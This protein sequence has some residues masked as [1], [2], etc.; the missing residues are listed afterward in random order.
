M[1]R[2]S[3]DSTQYVRMDSKPPPCR[4][5]TLVEGS[6]SEIESLPDERVLDNG[7]PPSTSQPPTE[8]HTPRKAPPHPSNGTPA[9]P[10]ATPATT[11]AFKKQRVALAAALFSE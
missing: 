1:S 7:R 9:P 11:A 5:A 2:V 4:F 10:P 6:D 8:Y 3:L